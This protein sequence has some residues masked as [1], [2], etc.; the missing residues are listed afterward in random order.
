[1]SQLIRQLKH[2]AGQHEQKSHGGKGGSSM[3]PGVDESSEA[4]NKSVK[5]VE[6]ATICCGSNPDRYSVEVVNK[7]S[8]RSGVSKDT[9]RDFMNMWNTGII[10]GEEEGYYAVLKAASEELGISISDYHK[11][12]FSAIGAFKPKLMEDYKKIARAMYDET[13]AEFKSRGITEIPAY[14]GI[15]FQKGKGGSKDTTYKMNSVESWTTSKRSAEVFAGKGS[16]RYDSMLLSATIPASRILS[17]P[18]TGIGTT[19]ESEYV[20]L[21]GGNSDNVLIEKG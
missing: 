19:S 15:A 1:M 4:Y 18:M 6:D 5:L 9:T 8:E 2:L 13:Q 14:R 7:I 11:D 16:E 17:T 20:V 10:F 12:K 3:R 21:G